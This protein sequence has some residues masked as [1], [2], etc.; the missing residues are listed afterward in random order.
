M[1]TRDRLRPDERASIAAAIDIAAADHTTASAT[2]ARAAA[3]VAALAE[4]GFQRP[5]PPWRA[6]QAT[7]TLDDS[8]TPTEQ[9]P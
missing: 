9:T 4:H 6:D 2:A 5:P 1:A 8:R 3:K 7:R